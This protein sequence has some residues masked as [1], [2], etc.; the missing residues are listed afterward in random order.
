MVEKMLDG[1]EV[2]TGEDY[3]SDRDEYDALADKVIYTGQIDEYY[4]YKFG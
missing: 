2:K 1:I 3:L 4:G